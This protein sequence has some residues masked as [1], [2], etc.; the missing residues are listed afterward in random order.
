VYLYR[1]FTVKTEGKK[2]KLKAKKDDLA[3]TRTGDP[4]KYMSYIAKPQAKQV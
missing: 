1:V 4:H 3:W 2:I